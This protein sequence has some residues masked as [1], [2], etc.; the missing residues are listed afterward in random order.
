MTGA[1]PPLRRRVR[2]SLKRMVA[3]TRKE[4]MHIGRDRSTLYFALGMPLVLLILFGY[5]VSFDVDRVPVIVVDADGSAES[6]SLLAHLEAGGTFRT[7]G[8]AD[9]ADAAVRR[10]RTG[11][12]AVAVVIPD[13]YARDLARGDTVRVQVLIDAADNTTAQSVLSYFGRL[14]AHANGA[15]VRDLVGDSAPT[16]EARIR[17][18]YNPSARS[19]VFLLPGL[20]AIIQSM[21]GA[22]L[23]ALAVAREWERGSMEQLF[24]TPVG[25]LE[26]VVGKLVP[27]FLVGVIQLLLILAAGTWLFDVP[28]RGSL[29]LLSILSMLFLVSVLAQ[30]LL[31]SVVTRNQM[32]ATQAAA[33]SS[34]LPSM[35]LSGFILPIDNMPTF[36]QVITNVIPA[37]HYV[38]GLRAVLLRDAPWTE[39]AGN[40]LALLVFSALLIAL[41]I[42]RFRRRVA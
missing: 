18:L 17:A 29:L 10:F 20:I 7:V 6:R 19:V 28:I 32:V 31:I 3:I 14:A 12:A 34:M 26:I 8:V 23:T 40:A 13:H 22:L 24:A 37:R 1:R 4:W 21:M 27:Y 36:L 16:V 39:V 9:D 33:M 41:C 5:A 38:D 35:M 11:D 30:G 15:L 42:L 2:R 25:R